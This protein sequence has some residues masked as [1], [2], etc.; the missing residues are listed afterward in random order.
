M[1]NCGITLS[2]LLYFSSVWSNTSKKNVLKLQSVQNFAAGIIT[3]IRKFDHITPA[4]QELNW[5]PVDRLLE[6]RDGVLAFKCMKGLAPSYLTDNLQKRNTIH[7]R[8]IRNKDKLVI[9]AYRS[10]SGQRTFAYRTQS[11]THYRT[12]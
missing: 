4:L 11:G 6:Y 7:S 3:G 12:V 9:S 10:A 5:L 8:N 1:Q 2:R